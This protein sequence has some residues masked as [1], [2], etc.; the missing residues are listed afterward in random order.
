MV[1]QADQ[2][3]SWKRTL[4]VAATA[5][6]VA[7][8]AGA[9]ALMLAILMSGFRFVC[10][11]GGQANGCS[12]NGASAGEIYVVWL[13]EALVVLAIVALVV[14]RGLGRHA[15]TLGRA[16]IAVASVILVATPIGGFLAGLAAERAMHLSGRPSWQVPLLASFAAA[17]LATAAIRWWANRRLARVP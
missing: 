7:L 17:V 8:L 9:V 11:D 13:V 12:H 16:R 6:T 3:L 10:G 1:D 14:E 5:T 15:R 2:P 4:A